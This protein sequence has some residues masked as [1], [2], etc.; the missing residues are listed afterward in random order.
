MPSS[1]IIFGEWGLGAGTLSTFSRALCKFETLRRLSTSETSLTTNTLNGLIGD[2][3]LRMIEPIV[4]EIPYMVGPGNHEN[5][6]NLTQFVDR[7]AMPVNEANQGTSTFYSFNL[8]TAHYVVFN[9]E[10]LLSS[11]PANEGAIQTQINWLKEDL[12]Q[13]NLERDIRPWIIL[14]THHP[15]Y[16]SVNW[17][18][19][20]NGEIKLKSN[21]D[22]GIDPQTLIPMLEDIYYEAGVDLVVQA[23]VHNYERDSPIY[24]NQTIPSDY[25]DEHMHM[26]AKAPVY[27]VSGN[28]GNEEGHND[29]ISPTP[30]LWYRAGSN[31]Y[32]FGKITVNQTHLYW[33]QFSSMTNDQ[34]DYVW[35]VKTN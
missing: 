5:F 11:D 10:W 21:S 3:Y 22:C 28:A 33:Q 34:I 20:L 17:R 30:Q 16:C 19:P 1:V 31:D 7:F 27:I 6:N 25:D 14:G 32:G 12:A 4:S 35:L 29:P 24:Q 8:G 18:L 23:H 13:A 2:M 9:T 26:N 15:L